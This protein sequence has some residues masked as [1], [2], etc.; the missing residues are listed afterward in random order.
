MALPPP[1]TSPSPER[2]QVNYFNRLKGQMQ[3]SEQEA[4]TIFMFCKH[5]KMPSVN[6]GEL[7]KL[8]LCKHSSLHTLIHQATSTLN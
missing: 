3:I 8:A 2:I 1:C 4:K 5:A 6:T 7:C